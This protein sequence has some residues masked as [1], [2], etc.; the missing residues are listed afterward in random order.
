[1]VINPI[2]G[3]YIYIY[4]HYNIRIPIKGGMTIPNIATFDHGTFNEASLLWDFGQ[5]VDE[6]RFILK[7]FN[8]SAKTLKPCRNV[9]RYS[10]YQPLLENGTLI[11]LWYSIRV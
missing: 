8:H 3:V 11:S 9:R 4:T 5:K 6:T 10:G 2:V 1:M 7:A